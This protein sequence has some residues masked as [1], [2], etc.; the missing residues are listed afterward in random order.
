MDRLRAL[1]LLDEC[2]G[3][4]IWSVDLCRQRGIPETWIDELVDCF[5]SGFRQDRETIYNGNRIVN[6]Y[7]GLYDVK[8]AHKLAEFLGIDV[9]DVIALQLTPESEVRALREAVEE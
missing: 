8:I 4:D 7:H 1:M 6:Q 3:R 5:E 2:T 9:A